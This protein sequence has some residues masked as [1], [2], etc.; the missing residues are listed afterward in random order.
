MTLSE[1]RALEVG[2]RLTFSPNIWSPGI[3]G[4][5]IE[6]TPEGVRIEWDD[7]HRGLTNYLHSPK[8]QPNQEESR[9]VTT[10]P[11]P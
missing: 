1:L 8:F 2:S 5:V 10:S 11:D 3:A 9:H 7:G 6:I 4:R